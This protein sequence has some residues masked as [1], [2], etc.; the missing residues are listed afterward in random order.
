MCNIMEGYRAGVNLGGWISQFKE[1]TK[2]HFDTFIREEDLEQIASWGMD[3]VR[4]PIDYTVL[5]DDGKPFQYKEEGFAYIDRCIRWCE[6]RGM[7]IILDLHRA[8]G[9]AFHS[10]KENRLFEDGELQER[11]L[12]LWRTF[13]ERYRRYGGN[14]VFELLNEIVEPDSLRWNHLSRRTVETIREIDK[15]RI[16]IVGGNRYNSV[17]TLKE[18]EP[19]QDERLVYT[20]HFYEPHIFTHQKAG[21]EPPMRE[22]DFAVP[23][24]SGEEDYQKYRQLSAEFRRQLDFEERIGKEEIRRYLQPALEFMK[25]RNAPLYCGEY[26]VIVHAPMESNLRWH[27]DVC[28]ILMEYG[29]GRAVWTYK[30][31]DFPLVDRNSRI[32]DEEL[33]RIVSRKQI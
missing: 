23:Y 24:P 20:F 21:W 18:L 10:L 28:D 12:S 11:F 30:R 6:E 22:L 26:G 25:E 29:I 1:G 17:N 7:N 14:V 9:Y 5:E 3:H 13:A 8:P 31:M 33:I 16:I 15:E 2:E 19:V 27:K 4:L 32:R